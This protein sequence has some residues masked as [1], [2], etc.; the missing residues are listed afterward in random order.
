MHKKL[1]LLSLAFTLPFAS[2]GAEKFPFSAISDVRVS[3]GSIDYV[4]GI[5]MNDSFGKFTAI[6]LQFNQS[7]SWSHWINLQLKTGIGTTIG[8]NTSLGPDIVDARYTG[9]GEI[10]PHGTPAQLDLFE[11][12]LN[13]FPSIPIFNT[14]TT[15]IEPTLGFYWM[16]FQSKNR[17]STGGVVTSALFSEQMQPWV[18]SD[19]FGPS[20]GFFF[21]TEVLKALKMRI[22]GLYIMPKLIEKS[23]GFTDVLAATSQTYRG[24]R[25][26][27]HAL[28]EIDWAIKKGI[29]L[30]SCIDYTS[31][32]A[33]NV[34][35]AG[36]DDVE[37]PEWALAADNQEPIEASIGGRVRPIFG[38]TTYAYQ[39]ATSPLMQ[40]LRISW[41]LNFSY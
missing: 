9:V 19:Y 18:K 20:I 39:R 13:F 37:V 8:G 28:F 30:V 3:V 23:Y 15:Y 11:M 22:G 7:V 27:A 41:G 35:T 32:S 16:H 12:G 38:F 25:N 33:Q 17:N 14:K 40:R 1:S 29:N 26:G 10:V 36:N 4:T 24:R 31:L 2:G 6:D 34:F 5:L 21:S